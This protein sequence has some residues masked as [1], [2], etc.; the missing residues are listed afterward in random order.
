MILSYMIKAEM[1]YH[2]YLF[3]IN[4]CLKLTIMELQDPGLKKFQTFTLWPLKTG[5]KM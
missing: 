2:E 4:L 5:T 1:S 3:Q